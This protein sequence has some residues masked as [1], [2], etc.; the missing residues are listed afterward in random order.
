MID[1][2]FVITFLNKRKVLRINSIINLVKEIDFEAIIESLVSFISE[3]GNV[4]LLIV[5]VS[6][7]VYAMYERK[8]LKPIN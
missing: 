2:V 4:I 8:K 7:A 5:F 3:N 6:L 1:L